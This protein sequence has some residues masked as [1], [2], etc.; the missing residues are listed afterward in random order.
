[1]RLLTWNTQWGCGRDGRASFPRIVDVIRRIGNFDVICLQEVAVNHPG[2][3][4]S[5]GQDQVAILAAAFPG[6]SAH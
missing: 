1:M 6:C 4:G 2:L 5:A 3:A